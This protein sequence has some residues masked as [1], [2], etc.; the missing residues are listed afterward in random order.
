[1]I[2][3]PVGLWL[4]SVF[5]FIVL[6]S[7]WI[8]Y[9]VMYSKYKSQQMLLSKY[10]KWLLLTKITG[11][12]K[13]NYSEYGKVSLEQSNNFIHLTLFSISAALSLECPLNSHT[14]SKGVKTF[15]DK[16]IPVPQWYFQNSPGVLRMLVVLLPSQ[17]NANLNLSMTVT[18]LHV[19]QSKSLC[20]VQ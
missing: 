20:S 7:L 9:N 15:Q 14:D 17:I 19:Q 10:E 5:F 13:I 6:Y 4:I 8:F 11:E 1:M 12:I 2:S 18:C 3:G 16:H